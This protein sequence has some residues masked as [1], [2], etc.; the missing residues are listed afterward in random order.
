M[1][2]GSY[3]ATSSKDDSSETTGLN[4]LCVSMTLTINQ[5]LIVAKNIL[6][7]LHLRFTMNKHNVHKI[8]M[9]INAEQKTVLS[10]CHWLIQFLCTT[11]HTCTYTAYK[12][13]HSNQQLC[14]SHMETINSR[15]GIATLKFKT[16]PFLHTSL[17]YTCMVQLI[18][19]RK[20]PC[21]ASLAEVVLY[22]TRPLPGS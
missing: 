18:L 2:D 9:E 11:A 20:F 5:N 8:C 17:H 13:N 10:H 14:W 12:Y 7:M 21:H 16:L 19:G 3:T 4:I 22:L 6:T 15:S 1:S